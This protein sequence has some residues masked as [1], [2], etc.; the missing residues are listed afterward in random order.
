MKYKAI[1]FDIGNVL[2]DIDYEV[3]IAAFNKIARGDFHQQVSYSHQ[4]PIFDQWE[5]GEVSAA[6]FRDSLRPLL[7][8]GVTDAQID[9]AWNSVLVAYP[10]ERFHRLERL[11]QHY[12]LYVLS[13]INEIH[14]AAIDTHIR[15]HFVQPDMRSFFDEAFYS[16]EIGMR[17]PEARIYQEVIARTGLL[18]DE[19]IFIDD[20]QENTAAAA[21]QGWQVHT[22]TDRSTILDWMDALL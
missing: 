21:L 18:P 8:E 7:L 15:K 12:N 4:R 13:N 9:Q 22:L 17:K 20:K 19:L 3:M 5:R 2:I 16:H 10:P 6:E 1:V 14:L 11:A